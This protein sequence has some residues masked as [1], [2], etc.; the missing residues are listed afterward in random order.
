MQPD[1]ALERVCRLLWAEWDPFG[2]NEL[3]KDIGVYAA[4]AA[5]YDAHATGLLSCARRA[6]KA[7][8]I[9]AELISCELQLEGG[10]YLPVADRHAVA[11]RLYDIARDEQPIAIFLGEDEEAALLSAS[12]TGEAIRAEAGNVAPH[13]RVMLVARDEAEALIG[14]YYAWLEDAD[15]G[16]ALGSHLDAFMVR[17]QSAFACSETRSNPDKADPS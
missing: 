2:V 7:Q 5:V 10:L 1:A 14:R 15:L 12:F 3:S 16:T 11:R 13:R 9:D 6:T 4:Y 17:L 8:D